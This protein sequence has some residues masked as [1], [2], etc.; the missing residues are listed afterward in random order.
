MFQIVKPI[1]DFLLL[2]DRDAKGFL[3]RDS[4]TAL[5]HNIEVHIS[6]KIS[7]HA[8]TKHNTQSYTK[9]KGHNAH[10]ECKTKKVKPSLTGQ[11]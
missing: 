7:H 6:H 4:D 5:R 9:N 3:L 2:F 11:I 1:L 8:Q 10:N